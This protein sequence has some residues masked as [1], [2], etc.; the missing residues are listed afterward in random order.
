ML[1][2]KTADLL[3]RSGKNWTHLFFELPFELSFEDA[4]LLW[5]ADD[6]DPTESPDSITNMQYLKSFAL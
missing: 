4:L 2:R 3:I 6:A 5:M 1:S